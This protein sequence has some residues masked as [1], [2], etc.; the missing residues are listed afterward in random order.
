VNATDNLAA[1]RTQPLGLL[2]TIPGLLALSFEGC[3]GLGG[4]GALLGS[5]VGGENGN[6]VIVRTRGR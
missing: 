6:L 5:G 3:W 4:W 2:G 1:T